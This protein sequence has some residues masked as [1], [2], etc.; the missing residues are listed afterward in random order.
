MN[1]KIIA[2]VISLVL[3]VG[4]VIG[5][6]VYFENYEDV[7]YTRVENSG[8]KELPSGSDMKYEYSLESYNRSGSRKKLQFKASKQLREGAFL[9]LDVKTFGVSKWEE[10][11][12]EDM[13][14]KVQEVYG[15]D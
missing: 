14:Q 13:P 9:M 12:F 3:I 11:Q 15:E 8:A 10:V 4:C 2:A 6:L 5:C 1:G 7:Y